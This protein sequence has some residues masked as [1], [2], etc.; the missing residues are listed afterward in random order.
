MEGGKSLD[1]M[2]LLLVRSC[3]VLTAIEG[4]DRVRHQELTLPS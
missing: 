4:E 1:K 3:P 2:K